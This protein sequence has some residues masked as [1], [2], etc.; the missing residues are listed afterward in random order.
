MSVEVFEQ[1][2]RRA[3]FDGH[4][5]SFLRITGHHRRSLEGV[6]WLEMDDPNED[7]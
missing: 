2:R 1:G 7:V 3:E 4:T 6:W 5:L